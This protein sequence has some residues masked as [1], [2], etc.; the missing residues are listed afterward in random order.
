MK[1][2]WLGHASFLITAQD[3]TRIIT[4]PYRPNPP[5]LAYD[6]VNE[7]A[8]IVTVSHEHGDHNQVSDV[9]GNPQIVRGV[10]SHEAKGIGFTGVATYHDTERGAQ[11]GENTIFC[12]T[13]DGMRLCHLGDLGHPISQGTVNEIGEVDIMLTVAGGGPTIGVP[14]ANEIVNAIKPKVVIPMHL[15]TEKCT[16][17][18]YTADDFAA[19]KS[20]VR[21][22]GSSE[23]EFTKEGLPQSTEVV[24]L[25]HAL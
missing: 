16:F 17:T 24:I 20:S 7:S 18:Q 4:D 6:R 11:R 2:K 22:V 12:F 9:S 1:I 5:S 13:V 3:G 10:G 19:G 14:Q 25:E 15:K 23:T 21:R 8:D